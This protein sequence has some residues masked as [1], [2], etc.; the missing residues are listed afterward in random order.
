MLARRQHG[1]DDVGVLDRLDHREGGRTTGFL[2]ARHGGFRKV[3]GDDLI[4]R[5]GL[6]GGHAASHVAEAD[7]CDFRHPV[8]LQSWWGPC[9]YFPLIPAKAGPSSFA[10]TPAA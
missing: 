5:L 2:R 3:E 4:A 8:F 10:Q 9:S 1:D 6:V 7:E